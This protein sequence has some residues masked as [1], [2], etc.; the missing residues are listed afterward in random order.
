MCVRAWSVRRCLVCVCSVISKA[1]TQK[2]AGRR[3]GVAALCNRQK[4]ELSSSSISS[5]PSPPL[6]PNQTTL[7]GGP[8]QPPTNMRAMCD[9]CVAGLAYLFIYL[10]AVVKLAW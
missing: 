1:M 2:M 10:Y 4:Q 9:M 3:Q 8:N 7:G 6:P 5:P